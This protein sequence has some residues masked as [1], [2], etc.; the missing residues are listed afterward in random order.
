MQASSLPEYREQIE[1]LLRERSQL[2]AFLAQTQDAIHQEHRLVLDHIP[3]RESVIA[4]NIKRKWADRRDELLTSIGRIDAKIRSLEAE[5][6][7]PKNFRLA[8]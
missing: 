5:A 2:E 3:D 8:D 4:E 7:D 1:Q 6:N